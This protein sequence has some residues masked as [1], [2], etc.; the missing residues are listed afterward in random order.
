[1]KVPRYSPLAL[2]VHVR[3]RRGKAVGSEEGK[4]LGSRFYYEQM[5]EVEQGLY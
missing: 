5:K 3:L 4:K 2:L 1:V